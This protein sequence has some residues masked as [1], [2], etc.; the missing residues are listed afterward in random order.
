MQT[1]TDPRQRVFD[2]LVPVA[3]PVKRAVD[4]AQEAVKEEVRLCQ[5]RHVWTPQQQAAVI[6]STRFGYTTNFLKQELS[7]VSDAARFFSTPS[8]E[9]QGLFLW[10]AGDVCLRVKREPEE[11]E[12]ESVLSLLDDAPGQ[13]D[14]SACLAWRSGPG[15]EIDL[16]RFKAGHGAP[17]VIPLDELLIAGATGNVQS[18]GRQVPIVVSKRPVPEQ[19]PGRLPNNP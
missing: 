10:L 12:N 15:P 1:I 2:A 18:I 8:Q 9:S 13:A 5:Q 7:V 3:L 4:R 6:G 14:L 17:W 11:L 19:I 16:I